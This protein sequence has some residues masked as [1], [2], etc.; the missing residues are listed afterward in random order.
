MIPLAGN[1]SRLLILVRLDRERGGELFGMG[2]GGM[3]W[4]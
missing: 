3:Y 1:D 4:H 2:K